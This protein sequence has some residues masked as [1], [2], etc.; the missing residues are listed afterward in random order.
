MKL[1]IF[2]CTFLFLVTLSFYVFAVTTDT[3]IIEWKQPNGVTFMGRAWG[4]EFRFYMET[5]EGYR[6]I[7]NYVDG[8][9][10]YAVL[11][12][13]GEFA[14]SEY[15]VGIDQPFAESYQLEPSAAYL[16][17][18]EDARAAFTA[19][20]REAGLEFQQRQAEAFANN[21]AVEYSIGIILAEFKDVKHFKSGSLPPAAF[22]IS[23]IYLRSPH[24]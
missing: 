16:E 5:D 20:V 9:Y 8:Y 13:N 22:F 3:G 19:Q 11:D 10:Y 15:K 2:I 1:Q 17:Q 7:K 4:D 6:F 24:F 14:P 18:V 23:Q 12:E 21:R